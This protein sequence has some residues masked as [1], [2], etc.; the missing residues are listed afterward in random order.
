PCFSSSFS[1]GFRRE[2]CC[3]RRIG[4]ACWPER[5][6]SAHCWWMPSCLCCCCPRRRAGQPSRSLGR[7]R[8]LSCSF[9]L[10]DS[11]FFMTLKLPSGI[12]PAPR[13]FIPFAEKSKNQLSPTTSSQDSRLAQQDQSSSR[14]SRLSVSP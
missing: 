4:S 3:L 13:G 7:I 9:S 14:S 8:E 5:T 10:R 2:C 6:P 12:E 11:W 1:P